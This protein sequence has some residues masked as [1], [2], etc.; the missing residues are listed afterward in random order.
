M[1]PTAPVPSVINNALIFGF[2]LKFESSLRLSGKESEPSMVA[3][4]IPLAENKQ[5][6]RFKLFFQAEKTILRKIQ[7]VSA[8]KIHESD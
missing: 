5:A 2:D 8:L 6:T 3:N 4:G 7:L 1:Y